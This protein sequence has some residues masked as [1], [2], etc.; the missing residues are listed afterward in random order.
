M[1]ARDVRAVTLFVLI[2]CGLAWL[3]ALPLWLGDGLASPLFIVIAT[4]MMATPSVAALVVVFVVERP[5]HRARALGL[6]PMAP[7]GRLIGYLALGLVVPIV[8]AV[9]GLLV[10]ALLGVYPADFTGFSG[11]AQTLDEQLSAAGLPAVPIPIGVMVALQFVNIVV[12][13]FLNLIPAFGEELGWRGWLLPKLLP[14]GTVPALLVSGLIWGL[15]HAPLVLL[16]YNYAGAPGWLAL[17]M[18]C[19]MCVVVGGVLGWLR[20]RS[21]SVWPAALAHGS[22][23]AAVGS[24]MIMFVAADSTVDTTQATLLGWSGWIVPL[25]LIAVLLATGQ[26]RPARR[27]GDGGS[28]PAV[29]SG[30]PVQTAPR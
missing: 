16:G 5:S 18:M 1:S 27:A 14:L 28:G 22:L 13:A 9:A 11:F 24:T 17:T 7:A 19:G 26:F 30:V 3:V 8:L 6:W 20:L 12:A 2:A 10:G 25:V 29:S 15:W 23:N 21:E 4:A